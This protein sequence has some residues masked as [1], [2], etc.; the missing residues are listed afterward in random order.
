MKPEQRAGR[1]SLLMLITFFGAPLAITFVGAH[2]TQVPTTLNDFFAPGTQPNEITVEII[3]PVSCAGCHGFFNQ[4]TEPFRPWAASMMGQA[5]RDPFFYACLAIANQDAAFAGDI[6]IRCHVPAGWLAGRSTPT[7]GSALDPND[8]HGVSCNFCHRLVDP[9]YTAGQSPAVDEEIIDNLVAGPPVNPHSG[10]FVVDPFDRR[11]GPYDLGTFYTHDWLQSPYHPSS[12][13]CGNCHDVSNPVFSRQPDGTYALNA[14]DA[15]PPS[16]DKYEQFPVER[17]YSEWLQSSFAAG[18]VEMGGRFGGNITAVSS[19]QDCHMPR[20]EGMGCFFGDVRP[21]LGRH[22]FNGGNTWV[23]NA[24]RNLYPDE[25]TFLDPNSVA[26]SIDRAVA[27]L[28]AASDLELSATATDLDVRVINQGGHKL[29]TGYP[30]GRRVWINVQF[31]NTADVLIAEHGYYDPNSATLTTADTRVY[32]A[33]LGP[34]AVVAALTG[35]PEGPSFHFVLAN[36][37]YKDNRIP[38]RGF[39]NAG[40]AAVQA[41]PVGATY[42]DGQH[43]DDV[44]FP[45]PAGAA[46]ADVRVYYQLTSRE[47]VEFLRDENVTNDAGQTLFDQW[48]LTGRS[49]PVEIDFA[50]LAVGCPGDLNGDQTIDLLD[51]SIL[52]AH[53]GQIGGATYADGDLTGDGNVDLIDLSELLIV[54]GTSCG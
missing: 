9:V 24:I 25:E 14:L 18:P 3:N 40:Y 5:A 4:D 27:L 32:E 49:A 28:E 37:Y 15:P 44:S 38:P 29:P 12:A 31:F 21:H 46:R 54:F 11:R 51:L 17:T 45:I 43:W 52:L 19:C 22:F 1:S 20:V 50:T 41:A 16:N 48:L 23:L 33:K 10:Q 8:L 36:V 30:E 6:C 35:V 13:L 2:A 47:Y 53:F 26:N 34:D 39:T 7:D 42:A